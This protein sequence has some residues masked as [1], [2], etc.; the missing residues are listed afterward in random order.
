M[1]DRIINQVRRT[2]DLSIFITLVG[3]RPINK[4]HVK[5]LTKS[6]RQRY[7]ETVMIVNE[8]FEVIDGQH[9]LEALK[10]LGLPA[11]Y[12][13]KVGY[14]LE[15]T[16]ILNLNTNDWSTNDFM[17][18]YCNAG[19]E[20]YITYRDWHNKYKFNHQSSM[21]LLA[22][23]CMEQGSWY[24]V[25]KSGQFTVR[26]LKEATKIADKIVMTK[27]YY[28]GYKRRGFV[29]AMTKALLDPDYNHAYF[30]KKLK[31]LSSSLVDCVKWQQ[32]SSIIEDI[33]N[34]RTRKPN[35]I[36]LDY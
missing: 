31:Y 19:E 26:N 25:F 35:K 21:N 7:L 15:E 30:M 13:I 16:Q 34:Y 24:E 6:I 8:D 36:R 14:G 17:N 12:I 32:Y 27:E 4:P 3:N 20:E 1:V 18:G 5:R 11:Y 2:N 23:T 22:G 9:R 33:Y 10:D 28:D 29:S